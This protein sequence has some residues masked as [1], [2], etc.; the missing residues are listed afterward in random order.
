MEGISR[1]LTSWKVTSCSIQT[2]L[3]VVN[4][5]PGS[6]ELFV[7]NRYKEELEKPFPKL[8]FWLCT[9]RDMENLNGYSDSCEPGPSFLTSTAYIGMTVREVEERGVSQKP[10]CVTSNTEVEA[11]ALSR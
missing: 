9:K 10:N 11:K 5:L 8:Y 4:T 1:S 7:L 2:K 3:A 6:A